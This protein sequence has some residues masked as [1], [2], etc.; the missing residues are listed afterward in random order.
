MTNSNVQ[1]GEDE[2]S[3]IGKLTGKECESKAI[4][5]YDEN[6]YFCKTI[7]YFI[8]NLTPHGLYLLQ[9]AEKDFKESLHIQVLKPQETLLNGENAWQWLLENHPALKQLNW[10][11]ERLRLVKP[12]AKTINRSTTFIRKYCKTCKTR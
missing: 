8:S 9:P 10:L 3:T 2:D 6:C 11:A 1:I 5:F 7:A 12:V 4:I